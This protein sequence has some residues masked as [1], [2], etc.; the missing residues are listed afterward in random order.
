MFIVTLLIIT[1]TGNNQ[2]VDKL[3]KEQTMVHPNN[4]ILL[5]NEKDTNQGYTEKDGSHIHYAKQKQ[6]D[7]K[8]M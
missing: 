3:L 5:R 8:A 6:P 4:G 1:Q 7:S 2:Y